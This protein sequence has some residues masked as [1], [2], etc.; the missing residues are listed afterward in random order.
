MAL[1]KGICKNFDNCTLAEKPEIQEVD[2]SEFRCAECGKELY[3][4]TEPPKRFPLKLILIIVAALLLIGGGIW[5]YFGLIKDR[6]EKEKESVSLSL[7]KEVI[8]LYVG[9]N[10]TLKATVSTQPSNAKVSVSFISDNPSVVNLSNDGV[11]K[12]TGQGEASI[13]VIARMESGAA[14]TASVYVTVN[15]MPE[16]PT[17][18]EQSNN[19]DG[20][21][22]EIDIDWNVPV[23]VCDDEISTTLNSLIGKHTNIA[24]RVNPILRKY[25]VKN[26]VVDKIGVNGSTLVNYHQPIKDYLETICASKYLNKIKVIEVKRNSIGRI[27]YLK[28]QEVH[29]RDP[30]A[31]E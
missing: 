29:Y 16:Q 10:D 13:T 6:P 22:Q 25:F 15:K 27:S 17:P 30:Q 31:K 4:Y 23:N 12:A 2:S 5:A 9:E 19:S 28:V 1:K 20:R 11:V 18:D 7:N 24:A 8:S 3:E 26:A 21:N 14:D